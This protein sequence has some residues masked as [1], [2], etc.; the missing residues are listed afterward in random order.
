MHSHLPSPLTPP[1]VASVA[2]MHLEAPRVRDL[3]LVLARDTTAMRMRVRALRLKRRRVPG[4]VN[5][6]LAAVWQAD[7][8]H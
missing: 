1:D 3:D 5:S 8:G 7:G 4:L 6:E 2:W